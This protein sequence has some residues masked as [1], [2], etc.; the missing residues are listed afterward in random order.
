MI[1][2]IAVGDVHGQWPELW[3]VLKAAAACTNSLE[4][5]APVIEGRYQIVCVGDL[6][7]YKDE[8]AYANAVGE[9]PYD[10]S[11]PDHL[12]RAAKAQIRELYRFKRYVD[13]AEGN[14]TI[15]L[16]NHDESALDHRYELS[17]RGGLKHVEFDESQGGVAMP[18]DLA[19]WFR[20]MPRER[21]FHGVQF[22]H[23]GPLPGMQI[24]DDFFYHDPDTKAWW[25]KKP[26]LVK[27]AGHRFGVYGH[28]VMKEGVYIDRDHC[29]AMIDALGKLQFLELIL[30]DDRL[31]YSLMQL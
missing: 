20:E 2:V 25:Y 30:A 21:F 14:V 3:R 11:N 7:H 6:V 26:E 5:T 10:P 16:G 28:T 15:I 12:R 18:E 13:A 4:P 29:F 19:A 22:A 17:T 23:A 1:K 24:F 9:E 8:R 27:L 31:D